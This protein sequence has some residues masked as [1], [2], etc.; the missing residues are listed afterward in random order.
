LGQLNI[1]N[2]FR[3][4]KSGQLHRGLFNQHR[5]Y[6]SYLRRRCSWIVTSSIYGNLVLTA[7]QVGLATGQFG[8]N[9]RFMAAAEAF[10]ISVL[11]ALLAALVLSIIFGVT[12]HLSGQRGVHL[13]NLA[14][15]CSSEVFSSKLD[16]VVHEGAKWVWR[17]LPDE[18]YTCDG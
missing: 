2:R 4:C 8:H 11:L 14:F 9:V 18:F 17:K 5:D 6:G 7:L 13:G 16:N 12:I 3:F 15:E 1:I 10:T